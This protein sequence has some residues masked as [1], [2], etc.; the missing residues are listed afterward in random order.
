[1]H[2]HFQQMRTHFQHEVIRDFDHQVATAMS[3]AHCPISKQQATELRDL[4]K[5][6]R[7][8]SETALQRME[9][10]R[11]ELD[12]FEDGFRSPTASGA[13]GSRSAT[14]SPKAKARAGGFGR[15]VGG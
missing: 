8:N 11:E 3:L 10:E 12:E 2:G 7:E 6:L 5:R 13:S 4:A 15:W 14:A 1:M 9:Q